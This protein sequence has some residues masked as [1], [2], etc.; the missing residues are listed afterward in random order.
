MITVRQADDDWIITI[1]N[2]KWKFQN[3]EQLFSLLDD[4]LANKVEIKNIIPPGSVIK[5]YYLELNTEVKNSF[6]ETTALVH[7]ILNYKFRC[8]QLR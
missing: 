3:K 8:G 1:K 7:K 2:E 6:A 4:L 5:C